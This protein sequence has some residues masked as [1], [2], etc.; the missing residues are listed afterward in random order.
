[1]RNN[2]MQLQIWQSLSISSTISYLILPAPIVVLSGTRGLPQK[3]GEITPGVT[4]S[5]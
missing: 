1:M 5:S 3:E 4:Y 2:H